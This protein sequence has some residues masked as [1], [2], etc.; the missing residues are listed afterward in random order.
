[1]NEQVKI[2]VALEI[3]GMRIGIETNCGNEKEINKLVDL[4]RDIYNGKFEN[5]NSILAL[6]GEEVKRVFKNGK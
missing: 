3:L 1:M 5:I 4:R 2:E 6:Y